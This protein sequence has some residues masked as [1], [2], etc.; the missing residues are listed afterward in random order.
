VYVNFDGPKALPFLE[1]GEITTE[2]M[3][4]YAG[5]GGWAPAQLEGEVA[6]HAWFVAESA[7]LSH[8]IEV[9]GRGDHGDLESPEEVGDVAHP[10]GEGVV[11]VREREMRDRQ[12]A[13]TSVPEDHSVSRTDQRSAPPALSPNALS[14]PV[15]LYS[16]ISVSLLVDDEDEDESE[17]EDV[18][19]ESVGDSTDSE[20]EFFESDVAVWR[21]AMSALGGEYADMAQLPATSGV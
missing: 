8:L 17:E 2:R 12:Y 1:R 6:Q 4:V 10:E 3:R 7:N 9:V 19:D 5:Y 16:R 11:P 21:L 15:T 20:D 14:A 18:E 13:Q